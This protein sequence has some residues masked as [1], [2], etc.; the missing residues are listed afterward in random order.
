[1][2]GKIDEG[3]SRRTHPSCLR[4][5]I[6]LVYNVSSFYL[7]EQRENPN[8]SSEKMLQKKRRKTYH[9]SF[10]RRTYFWKNITKANRKIVRENLLGI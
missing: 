6:R 1:M 7:T 2:K 5:N 10:R 4:E 3:K 9:S 8:E